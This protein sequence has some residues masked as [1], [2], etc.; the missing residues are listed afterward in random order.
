MLALRRT[1]QKDLELEAR[2]GYGAPC[3]CRLHRKTLPQPPSWTDTQI[4]KRWCLFHFLLLGIK[5]LKENNFREIC[6]PHTSTHRPPWLGSQGSSL[7]QLL[8]SGDG[9]EWML[10]LSSLCPLHSPGSWAVNGAT[11][12]GS[13]FPSRQSSVGICRGLSPLPF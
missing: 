8:T 13:V 12:S 4:K 1:W 3:H 2:L 6:F 7:K 10:L 9:D 5:Y 11:C